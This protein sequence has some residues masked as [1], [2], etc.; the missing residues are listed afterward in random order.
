MILMEELRQRLA[1]AVE[2]YSADPRSIIKQHIRDVIPQGVPFWAPPDLREK[3]LEWGLAPQAGALGHAL[4]VVAWKESAFLVSIVVSIEHNDSMQEVPLPTCLSAGTATSLREAAYAALLHYPHVRSLDIPCQLRFRI[5]DLSGNE[6]D[7]PEKVEGRS[8]GLA[9]A[10][11]TWS[12]LAQ[13]PVPPGLAFTGALESPLP[14]GQTRVGRVEHVLTKRQV[15]LS[16]AASLVLPAANAA[17]LEPSQRCAPVRSVADALA[18][19]FGPD[20]LSPRVCRPP[21]AQDVMADLAWLDMRYKRN[22]EGS[23]WP[24]FAERFELFVRSSALPSTRRIFAVA[25]AAACWTHCDRLELAGL[26]RLRLAVEQLN[27]EEVDATDEVAARTHL[28]NAYRDSYLFEKAREQ[29][30]LAWKLGQQLR[31]HDEKVKALSTL[32]Q[33]L[34]AMGRVEEGF[35][36]LRTALEYFER[37]NP[38]ECARNHCYLIE[39]LGRAG[40]FADAEQE[41]ERGLQHCEYRMEDGPKRAQRA[42]LDYARLNAWLRQSRASPGSL[43]LWKQLHAEALR[44]LEGLESPWPRFGLERIRDAAA[45][46]CLT[47]VNEREAVL[48]RA[49]ERF[50]AR[51]G[52]LFGWHSGLVFLEAA[53]AELEGGGELSKAT[54]W[55]R[56]G[57]RAV[58]Y[59]SARRFLRT[60]RALRANSP[61]ALQEVILSVVSAEQY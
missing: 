36:H 40:R 46:R 16:A 5:L 23:R 41:Y 49:A 9:A 55:L 13:A 38:L 28:A 21:P 56:T 37:S 26:D 43:V 42:F 51:P 4:G 25:R 50:C 2:R 34:V 29:A 6:L 24:E 33:I 57:L 58:P 39:A 7:L 44:A 32:G 61:S 22:S 10:V 54:Q 3:L 8:L 20:W 45:L 14:G 35:P 27:P 48:H 30:E 31:V 1:E 11:A 17:E 60:G 47:R 53:L 12:V 15:V 59:R 18:R 52:K 19:A